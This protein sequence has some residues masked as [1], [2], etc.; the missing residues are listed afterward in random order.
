MHEPLITRRGFGGLALLGLAAETA[1][2][3]HAAVQGAVPADTVWLNANENPEGPPVESREAI[4]K[5][6]DE[7]GRY[8][9]RAFPQM[10]EMLAESV[11]VKPEEVIVGAGSTEVLHCAIDAFVAKD[12]PLITVWPTWEMTRDVAESSGRPVIKVPLTPKWSA[13]VERLAAEAKKAGGGVIH[14]GNPNN[15]TSSITPRAELRWLAEHLPAGTVL[16]IDE[17]Y[18]QFADAQAI[19]SGI[20]YVREGRSVVAT[21]TFSKLYGMAGVRVGFGCAR[22]DL[23]GKMQPFRNNVI[24]ILGA[25]AAIAATRLGSGFVNERRERRNQL[26]TS[27]CRWLD[28]KRFRYIPPQ[29][30]FVLIDIRRPVQDVIPQMLAQGVA[31][32]RRFDTLDNWMRVAIGTPAEMEKFRGA[33]ERVLG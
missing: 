26:R 2:A 21:R 13:D 3:Q 11:R 1:F 30:N 7:A 33:F 19:E 12:R 25:R 18:I 27:L 14:M 29:A 4:A 31:V 15:P 22:E 8:N 16:V 17:A 10:V 24:S 9:H 5:A 23:V 20:E 32:G 28:E 6:I